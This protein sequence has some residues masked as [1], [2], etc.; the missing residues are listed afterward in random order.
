MYSAL[1]AFVLVASILS[2]VVAWSSEGRVETLPVGG[3]ARTALGCR[4]GTASDSAYFLDRVRGIVGASSPQSLRDMAGLPIVPPDS[5]RFVGLHA[6]CEAVGNRYRSHV[7]QL[8]GDTLAPL[9]PVLLLRVS[10]N[11][12][13]GDPFGADSAG[14]H[15]LYITV[16]SLAHTVSIWGV[17]M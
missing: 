11:R 7:N 12:Y 5:V 4:I 2:I 1:K 10:P 9:F 17:R 16:D 6:L 8:R 15:R 13:V 3:G 14:R